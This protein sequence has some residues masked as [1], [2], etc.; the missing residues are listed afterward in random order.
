MPKIVLEGERAEPVVN[1]SSQQKEC[2]VQEGAGEKGRKRVGCLAF[3]LELDV[4]FGFRHDENEDHKFPGD[5]SVSAAE[6]YCR[7]PDGE[8]T[9]WCYTTDNETRWDYCDV[10]N[11][12]GTAKGF[13][14]SGRPVK[15]VLRTIVLLHT[16]STHEEQERNT[17]EVQK[18]Q[19]WFLMEV[20]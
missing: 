12:P 14:V 17:I 18:P 8:P 2:K 3:C 6:N 15:T 5:G 1:R 10:P 19:S 20:A 9:L 7:N 13:E 4:V 16:P 11:C